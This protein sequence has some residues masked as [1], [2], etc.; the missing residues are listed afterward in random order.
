MI[1][2]DK[3]T[4]LPEVQSKIA[5]VC[6]FVKNNK[7]SKGDSFFIEDFPV[8]HISLL[9]SALISYHLAPVYTEADIIFGGRGVRVYSLTDIKFET[10]PASVQDNDMLNEDDL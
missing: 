7:M 5:E 10:S 8:H 1:T 3:N 6:D 2:M 4:P 9:A